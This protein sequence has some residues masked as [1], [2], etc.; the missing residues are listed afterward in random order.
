MWRRIF[1]LPD[2]TWDDDK[3]GAF[4]FHDSNQPQSGLSAASPAQC[5][6]QNFTGLPLLSRSPGTEGFLVSIVQ[7]PLLNLDR[8]YLKALLN[9]IET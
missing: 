8:S 6:P 5:S 9:H 1:S 2:R 3:I 7:M 4:W